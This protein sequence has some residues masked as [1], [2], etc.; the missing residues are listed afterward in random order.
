MVN[1]RLQSHDFLTGKPKNQY[2]FVF[3]ELNDPYVA[4]GTITFSDGYDTFAL[5]TFDGTTNT[6]ILGN[7][8]HNIPIN[9][10][11]ITLNGDVG[12]RDGDMRY[13]IEESCPEFYSNGSWVSMGNVRNFVNP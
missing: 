5:H 2:R 7:N 6:T 12:P 9:D 3:E 13:N 10:L 11:G 1:K 4:S 8:E